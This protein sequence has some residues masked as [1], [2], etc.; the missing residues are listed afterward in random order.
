MR[1]VRALRNARV[2]RIAD[3]R[4]SAHVAALCP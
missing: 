3:E 4:M 1:A 2:M